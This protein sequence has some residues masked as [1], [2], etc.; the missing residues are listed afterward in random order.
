MI[1]RSQQ[2]SQK[3]YEQL[4]QLQFDEV[5]QK[6]YGSLCHKFPLMVLRSGLAQAVAFVWVKGS[7]EEDSPQGVFLKHIAEL[8]SQAAGEAPADFQQRINGLELTQ[9]QRL[10]REILAASV[11]YKRFAESVLGVSGDNSDD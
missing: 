3:V 7:Q 9:Y 1:T 6:K 11:W 8:S 10:T 2:H 5:Q 4:S